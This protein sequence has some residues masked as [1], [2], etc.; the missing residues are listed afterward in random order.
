MNPKSLLILLCVS[1]GTPPVAESGSEVESG[2][3]SSSDD[4]STD[5]G[6]SSDSTDATTDDGS[7]TGG[8]S[9]CLPVTDMPVFLDC[10]PFAQD[11]PEGE[12]CV[13]YASSGG[14]WDANK[15]V[16]VQGTQAV[17]EPCIFGG[18]VEATDDCDA[19]S[20]CWNV[21]EVDGEM[22]GS[23]HGFCGGSADMPEC[24]EGFECLISSEPIVTLCFPQCDP[25][26]QNCADGLACYWTAGTFTCAP[27]LEPPGIP[28]GQPCGFIND[29]EPGSLCLDAS[30]VPDCAGASC[31]TS[32][33]DVGLGDAQCAAIPNTAC[34]SFWEQGMAPDGYDHVGICGVWP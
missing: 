9:L 20:F 29:C 4:G 1:C 31:C 33:C 17:G 13:P 23:C 14:S 5:G 6:S 10:D 34:V 7:M 25:V 19:D 22:V 11:C 15:C 12:K 26:A 32:V 27:P 2:G 8:T 21:Q 24:P 16:A 3:S 18:I 28:P 30:V